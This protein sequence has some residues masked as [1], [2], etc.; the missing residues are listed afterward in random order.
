MQLL[1]RVGSL[2]GLPL[3]AVAGS[4]G[5]SRALMSFV[6]L[7]ASRPTALVTP[8]HAQGHDGNNSQDDQGN[9]NYN[10]SCPDGHGNHQGVT[11][12]SPRRRATARSQ[13]SVGPA[14]H[15]PPSIPRSRRRQRVAAGAA[16]RWSPLAIGVVTLVVG[17]RFLSPCD[18]PVI[19]AY[20][21]VAEQLGRV[22]GFALPAGGALTGRG[23]PSVGSSTALDLVVALVCVVASHPTRLP[24]RPAPRRRTSAR[25]TDLHG[26]LHVLL[27]HGPPSIPP[28]LSL[29][30][31]HRTGPTA[32][33]GP[34][35]TS[36]PAKSRRL[37]DA[38]PWRT[39]RY[40]RISHV[41][42]ATPSFWDSQPFGPPGS[43]SH[44][45]DFAQTALATGTF[46]LDPSGTRLKSPE[47]AGGA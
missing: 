30:S 25:Q 35:G 13:D 27:R 44:K 10:D 32:N 8:A 18:L 16:G 23:S 37:P 3:R 34:V 33:A 42:R 45:D 46:P 7:T 1:G 9:H 4:F 15:R 41:T 39:P 26:R 47:S 12:L 31:E 29:H 21:G 5:S 24:R 19:F 17:V 11:L 28:Q 43:G 6:E 14:G 38:K 2:V 22:G 20:R 36:G 40:S